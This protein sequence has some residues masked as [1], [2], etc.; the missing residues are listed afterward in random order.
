MQTEFAK[1]AIALLACYR[2]ACRLVQRATLL[3]R[4]P[5]RQTDGQ[6]HVI[7]GAAFRGCCHGRYGSEAAIND[8][9]ISVF[10][11]TLAFLLGRGNPSKW[12]EKADALARP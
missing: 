12:L 11:A 9:S 4:L 8:V 3:R 6:S 7:F 2:S 5:S 1:S 10:A